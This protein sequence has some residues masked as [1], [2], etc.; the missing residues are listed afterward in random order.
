MAE[1]QATPSWTLHRVHLSDFK[2]YR[3][4]VVA[5]PFHHQL[6]TVI[7]ANGTG[8]SCLVEGI[9]FALGAKAQSASLS[10][11]VNHSASGNAAAVAVQFRSASGEMLVSERRIVGAGRSEFRLQLCRCNDVEGNPEDSAGPWVCSACAVR[12]I[13]LDEL[14]AVLQDRLGICIEHPERF[15]VHQSVSAPPPCDR[16][17]VPHEPARL[18]EYAATVCAATVRS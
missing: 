5:G 18:C 2:S 10:R 12:R 15:V 8:K 6:T 3:G 13:Q 17:G 9:A 7:G 4:S 11:L 14:R 1:P 16:E